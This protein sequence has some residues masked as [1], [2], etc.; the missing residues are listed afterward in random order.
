MDFK[1]DICRI[2]ASG[3]VPL[4]TM[5]VLTTTE[6]AYA[7][8][9]LD[10]P[11]YRHLWYQIN[12]LAE[13]NWVRV[14]C[15]PFATGSCIAL[16]GCDGVAIRVCEVVVTVGNEKLQCLG[17][18]V[19]RMGIDDADLPLQ[20]HC[21][22]SVLGWIN[23]PPMIG[24]C[25]LIDPILARGDAVESGIR[26]ELGS[27]PDLILTLPIVINGYDVAQ[28]HIIPSAQRAKL[29]QMLAAC[30]FDGIDRILAAD[31]GDLAF[32]QRRE[33][34]NGVRGG[35]EAGSHRNP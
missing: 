31:K 7:W 11:G 27:V 33:V 14:T 13:P 18:L 21:T 26:L 19:P 9:G 30:D 35:S 3:M 22:T 23:L 2:S 32:V 17:V 15:V 6:F 5:V 12:A 29:K 34:D 25:S 4:G 8:E 20:Y 16:W 24:E 10:G 28:L 1:L